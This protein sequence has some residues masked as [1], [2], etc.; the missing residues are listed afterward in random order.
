[1]LSKLNLLSFETQANFVLCYRFSL[2]L[3]DKIAKLEAKAAAVNGK[4][5]RRMRAAATAQSSW[6]M[7][8]SKS[9]IQKLVQKCTFNGNLLPAVASKAAAATETKNTGT[10]TPK[11]QQQHNK[12]H[13][14]A[15]AVERIAE[16]VGGSRANSQSL[17]TQQSVNGLF[18]RQMANGKRQR[19]GCAIFGAPR[20]C[21]P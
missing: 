1:M 17:D 15:V 18:A 10:H 3:L 19:Q 12:C 4:Q 16:R 6:A 9:L 11:V 14:V 5:Q 2:N 20:F 21:S 8:K 13:K 7:A